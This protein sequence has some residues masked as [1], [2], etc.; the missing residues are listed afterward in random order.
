MLTGGLTFPRTL[1][2]EKYVQDATDEIDSAIGARYV[3]PVDV[4]DNSPVARHSRLLLK[5]INNWLASGRMIL[6]V[7]TPTE[8]SQ[9]HAYGRSLI[10]DALAALELIRTGQVDLEG[11][12]PAEGATQGDPMPTT[13]NSDAV[14]AVDSFEQRFMGPGV[15]GE[16]LSPVPTWFPGGGR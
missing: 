10:R 7:A 14:S 13:I 6:A 4:D 5:R 9:V 16:V 11:A 8:H 1:D 3:T 2:P 12:Q 15:P